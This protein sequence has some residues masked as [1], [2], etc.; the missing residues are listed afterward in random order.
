MTTIQVLRDARA[1]VAIGWCRIHP[2]VDSANCPCP[3]EEACRWC[4]YGSLMAACAGNTE[5][6]EDAY[7]RIADT[8]GESPIGF[9]DA[10]GRTQAE[11]LAAFDKA[12][13]SLEQ[14]A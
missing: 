7:N 13:A 11:V 2:A 5:L 1:L 4:L 9:N 3:A 8:L 14:P 10:P 6:R 12:I